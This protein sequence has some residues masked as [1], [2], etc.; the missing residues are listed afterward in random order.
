MKAV[1]SN[2]NQ[3]VVFFPTR[4]YHSPVPGFEGVA[5]SLEQVALHHHSVGGVHVE[6]HLRVIVGKVL[7]ERQSRG[8]ELKRKHC[9]ETIKKLAIQY[10][11]FLFVLSQI[12]SDFPTARHGDI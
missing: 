3:Q 11:S 9:R 12:T 2:V 4:S 6:L 8:F 10:Q 7:K 1:R 5:G